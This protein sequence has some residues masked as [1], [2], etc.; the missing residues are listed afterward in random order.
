MSR[1]LYGVPSIENAATDSHPSP[2]TRVS[3]FALTLLS[4]AVFT[5]GC[6]PSGA[7]CDATRRAP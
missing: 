2:T 7:D 6:H 5:Y 1:E 3:R 4:T